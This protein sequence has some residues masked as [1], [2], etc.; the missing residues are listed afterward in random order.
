MKE[1]EDERVW[2]FDAK[3]AYQ[4]WIKG[5]SVGASLSSGGLWIRRMDDTCVRVEK[6]GTV[7]SHL[8][9]TTA[10][11]QVLVP[12]ELHDDIRLGLFLLD[13]KLLLGTWK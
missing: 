4:F 8:K 7:K 10:H 12:V 9:F 5:R 13:G 1:R 3:G 6:G 11:Q 2:F